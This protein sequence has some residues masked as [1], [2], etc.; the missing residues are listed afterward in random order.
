M[1]KI[2]FVIIICSVICFS[3]CYKSPIL[4]TDA[5]LIH[6]EKG[7]FNLPEEWVNSATQSFNGLEEIPEENIHV[8]L[9]QKRGFWNELFNRMQWE[10]TIKSPELNTTIVIDAHSGYFITLYGAYS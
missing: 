8:N 3:Y 9:S 10:V 5:A 1:K 4:S 6:A 7:L 2:V